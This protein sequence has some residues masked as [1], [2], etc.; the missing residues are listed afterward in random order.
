MSWQ[1]EAIA[2]IRE[3]GWWKKDMGPR[4][5]RLCLMIAL[6]SDPEITGAVRRSIGRI[7]PERGSV[8]GIG[9]MRIVA[10]NDH[11]DTTQED[12]ECVLTEAR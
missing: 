11:P 3:R 12:V 9:E 2:A 1:Q 5:G 6:P 4:D 8:R 7:F 10:F